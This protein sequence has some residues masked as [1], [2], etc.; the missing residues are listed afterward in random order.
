MKYRS[1]RK[2]ESRGSSIKKEVRETKVECGKKFAL[3]VR[4]LGL[5]VEKIVR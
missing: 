2:S 1:Q 4:R 5:E 3:G